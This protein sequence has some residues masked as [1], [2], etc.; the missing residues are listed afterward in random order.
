MPDDG[1]LEVVVSPRC[2]AS[3]ACVHA[4][5]H[6]FAVLGDTAS[7]LDPV[8]DPLD[9]V[10]AAAEACPTAAITVRRGGERLA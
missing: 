4:A 5:P 9:D 1:P 7:V 2:I 6:V 8:G 10:L 3:K